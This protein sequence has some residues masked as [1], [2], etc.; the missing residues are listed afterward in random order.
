MKLAKT[1]VVV[2]G[3]SSFVMFH[4]LTDDRF[5]AIALEWLAR[6]TGSKNPK[7]LARLIMQTGGLCYTEKQYNRYG[8]HTIKPFI[9]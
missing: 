3:A 9:K 6:P 7:D 2:P 1:K 5:K 8:K 4:N